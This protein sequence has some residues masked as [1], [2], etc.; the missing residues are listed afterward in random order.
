M[1]FFLDYSKESVEIC[2][3]NNNNQR[4]IIHFE[5]NELIFHRFWAYLFINEKN[6]TQ[7]KKLPSYWA[8]VY[9]QTFRSYWSIWLRTYGSV[10]I[11]DNKLSK[12]VLNFGLVPKESC[13]TNKWLVYTGKCTKHI[14]FFEYMYSQL[15]CTWC[16]HL[17]CYL[18]L[19]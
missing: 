16:I 5:A 3:N 1:Q 18:S 15:L 2:W 9:F 14:Y 10:K 4:L 7:L 6:T 11:L 8:I 12:S 19:H 17:A 13:H